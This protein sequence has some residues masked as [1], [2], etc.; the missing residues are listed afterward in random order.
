LT[1]ARL[2]EIHTCKQQ[3]QQQQQHCCQLWHAASVPHELTAEYTRRK[4]SSTE[5][6]QYKAGCTD[7]S[8]VQ[9]SFGGKVNM[10][11]TLALPAG[12]VSVQTYLTRQQQQQQPCSINATTMKA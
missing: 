10:S 9:A 8:L 6:R 4:T 2:T 7:S 5:D 11:V 1:E 3:Q 12:L